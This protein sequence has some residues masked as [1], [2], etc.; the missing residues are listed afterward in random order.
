MNFKTIDSQE[1]KALIANENA[2]VIDIRDAE[3]YEDGH[4]ANSIR[5]DG[6]NAQDFINNTDK[7]LPLIVCCY[8]GNMSK[9]AAE[10]FFNA[11][12]QRSFSLDGGYGG[13]PTDET[14][15]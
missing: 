5:V 3:S 12:F 7:E 15:A 13:W 14:M 10:H 4:I 9:S 6:S 1:A 2:I 11:G 8:H